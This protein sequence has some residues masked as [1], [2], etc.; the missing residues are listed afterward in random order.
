LYRHLPS[1]HQNYFGTDENLGPVAVSI[2]R[3]KLDEG[4]EG[5]QYNYRV[6]FRTSEVNHR[7]G[8]AA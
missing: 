2:R 6:T 7:K 1:D 8:D 4:K 5:A 3:E